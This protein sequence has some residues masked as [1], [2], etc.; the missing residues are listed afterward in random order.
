[1]RQTA[2]IS[3]VSW[4]GI[5]ALCLPLL[6]VSTDA[7]AMVN[8]IH[9]MPATLRVIGA[10]VLALVAAW[11]LVVFMGGINDAIKKTRDLRGD[12][13]A[14]QIFGKLLG[15]SALALTGVI[16]AWTI[17]SMGGN[18][19]PGAAPGRG[20]VAGVSGSGLDAAIRRLGGSGGLFEAVHDLLVYGVMPM[21]ALFTFIGAI[22]MAVRVQQPARM[23]Q[24]DSAAKVGLYVLVAVAAVHM[25]GISSG[26][27]QTMFGGQGNRSLMFSYTAQAAPAQFQQVIEAALRFVALM[28]WFYVASSTMMA[29]QMADGSAA[30][31]GESL[32]GRIAARFFGGVACI[33]INLFL[34]SLAATAGFGI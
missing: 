20:P 2:V 13:E 25:T 28:G 34:P 17:V 7:Q 10:S 5:S 8:S 4:R 23:R 18:A 6:F 11:G 33:N 32:L 16:F 30:Q 19:G 29:K 14:R 3:S 9:G 27:W 24:G 31:G 26:V 22:Q 1:M 21:L 15:G 12:I